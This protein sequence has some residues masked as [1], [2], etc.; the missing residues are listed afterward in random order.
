MIV[1]AVAV[2]Y[3]PG[4]AERRKRAQHTVPARNLERIVVHTEAAEVVHMVVV[5]TE[6]EVAVR[7]DFE[8]VQAVRKGKV[9]VVGL[10]HMTWIIPSC[11]IFIITHCTIR[12]NVPYH[13]TG[14][15][16]NRQV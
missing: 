1:L 4:L 12:D 6:I 14:V 2:A 7:T 8:V 13:T 11:R 3:N 10:D 9:I 16:A 15:K 5:R